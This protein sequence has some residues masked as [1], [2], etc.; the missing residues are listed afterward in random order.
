MSI[1]QGFGDVRSRARQGLVGDW[2][3]ADH[4]RRGGFGVNS[5]P[6]AVQ[7]VTFDVADPGDDLVVTIDIDGIVVSAAT[8]TG[9]N[10]TQIAALLATAINAEPL[11]RGKV[12]ATSAVAVVTLTG[13]NP[14][15]SV[16]VTAG[17]STSNVATATAADS[18]DPIP[19]G[20]AVIHTGFTSNEEES[21]ALPSF[22]AQVITIAATYVASAKIRVAVYEVLNGER[23][24]LAD[25]TE[26]SATSLDAT[27]DALAAALNTALPANSVLAAS[28][29]ATATAITLTAERAGMEIEVDVGAGDEGASVPVWTVTNTTGPSVA[30]SLARAFRGISLYSSSDQAPA[31]GSAGEYAGN[32]GVKFAQRGVV[33]VEST[34]TPAVGGTVYVETAAG[35]TLGRLYTTGSSTRVALPRSRATWDRPG[36]T[37]ADGIAA[38]RL[39]A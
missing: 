23:I 34:E 16:T 17:T 12:A 4:T 37:A 14:G 10:A 1:S 31:V 22:A 35:A 38:V 9:N 28:T 2:V 3:F 20:R 29:P 32:A 33:W 19:F 15:L 21:V 25:V 8:G 7:V 30:T 13:Q 11:V 6:Q 26:T 24:L 5:S 18:A 36:L 27:L 39:E